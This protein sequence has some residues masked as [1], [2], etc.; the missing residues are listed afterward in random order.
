MI[1]NCITTGS[2]EALEDAARRRYVKPQAFLKARRRLAPDFRVSIDE[3]IERYVKAGGDKPVTITVRQLAE[4]CKMSRMTAAR[5]LKTLATEGFI[6][7]EGQARFFEDKRKPNRYRLTMF[8]CDGKEATHNYIQDA[9]EWRRTGR[10]RKTKEASPLPTE[11]TL[12]IPRKQF[13][14]AIEDA[15][16][17]AAA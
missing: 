5:A 16:E 4:A 12:K 11:I 14:R 6:V 10:R 7:V 8:P 1:D 2:G 9:K 15:E 13:V 17:K 3:L